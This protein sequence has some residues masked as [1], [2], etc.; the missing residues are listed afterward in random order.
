MQD[1]KTIKKLM[2]DKEVT[3]LEMAKALNVNPSTL[4]LYLNGWRRMPDALMEEIAKYLNVE[5]QQLFGE[6]EVV[7]SN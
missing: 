5:P 4:S 2:L 1:L 6:V 3:A 7:H